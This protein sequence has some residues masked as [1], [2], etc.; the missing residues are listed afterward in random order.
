M[1]MQHGWPTSS[2][3]FLPLVDLL[4]KD[5]HICLLDYA[6]FGYSEKPPAPYSYNIFESAEQLKYFASKILQWKNFTYYTHDMGDSVGLTLLTTYLEDLANNVSPYS[7]HHH[8]ITNG[9]I[10][11]DLLNW[12]DLQLNLMSF[13]NGPNYAARLTPKIFANMIAFAYTPKLRGD[14]ITDLEATFEFQN[15]SY[16]S[17]GTIMYQYE[18]MLYESSWLETLGRLPMTTTMIW[19]LA[20]TTNPYPISD[21]VWE[22]ILKTR[23]PPA[24]YFKV[25]N[26]NHYLQYDSAPEVAQI[27]QNWASPEKT[28]LCTATS[29]ITVEDLPSWRR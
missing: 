19:G 24:C 23:Q 17:H 18:R 21:Y 12:T 13:Q 5:Y 28:L 27:I 7:I 4:K 26:A 20:D 6:G 16:R 14:E 3:D 9:G 29:P 22:T 8:V 1:L 11:Q 10:Y 15:G 2:I 25:P